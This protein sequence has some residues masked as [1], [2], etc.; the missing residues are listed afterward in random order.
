M[1][2]G[3]CQEK[4]LYKAH[5]CKKCGYKFSEE[6]RQKAYDKTI[7][8][9][10]NKV[11]DVYETISLDKIT[12]NI[13]FKIISILVVLGYGIFSFVNNGNE[14]KILDSDQ[15]KVQ[16]NTKTKEYY[17]LSDDAQVNVSLYLPKEADSIHVRE[18]DSTSTV[19]EESEYTIEDKII[20]EKNKNY[21]EVEAVYNDDSSETIVIKLF[22][23]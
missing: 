1:I 23:K 12:G 21:Y 3:K 9:T 11:K 5:Y 10:L 4:N 14:L 15:Y 18:F 17:L 7:Y 22:D 20:L 2:C 8:G 19:L 13:Y 6:E 16:Y